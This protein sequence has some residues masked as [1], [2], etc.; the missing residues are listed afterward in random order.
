MFRPPRPVPRTVTVVSPPDSSTLAVPARS[1]APG[2]ARAGMAQAHVARLALDRVAEHDGTHAALRRCRGGSGRASAAVASTAAPARDRS[3]SPGLGVSRARRDRPRRRR[4]GA[5]ARGRA[6]HAVALEHLERV[7]EV[8]GS[9]TVGPEAI[10]EG[11]SPGTSEMSEREHARRRG[12]RRQPAALD[13][14]EVL[15]HAVDGGDGARRCAAAPRRSSRSSASVDAGCRQAE[16]RR[17]AAGDQA[18][19]EIVVGKAGDG[20]HDGCAPRA[21]RPR[22]A[23]GARPRPPST[24]SQGTACP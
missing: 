21:G 5:A 15:A 14:R 22:R 6:R 17:G 12:G 2:R 4:A 7:G 9:A 20:G 24:R 16:Q 13:R 10:T 11:S 19:H 8:V 1:S 18:E 23:Q 3:G